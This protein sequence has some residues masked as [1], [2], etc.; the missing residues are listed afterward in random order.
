MKKF[1]R[2]RNIKVIKIIDD[3]NLG[4]IARVILSSLVVISFFYALP[5]IINFTNEKILNTKEFK[6][7]SKVIL[8]YTLD[9]KNNGNEWIFVQKFIF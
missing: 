1:L 7:N 9:K 6:N 5:L 8:A 2:K 3:N 4:S